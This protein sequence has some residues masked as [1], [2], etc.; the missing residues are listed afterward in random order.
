MIVE[1]LCLAIFGPLLLIPI[2]LVF[3]ITW[4]GAMAVITDKL[5]KLMGWNE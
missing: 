4:A 2:L 5:F 1:M 3:A